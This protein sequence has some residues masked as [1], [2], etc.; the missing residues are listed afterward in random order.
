MSEELRQQQRNFY[1]R[2]SPIEGHDIASEEGGFVA[3]SDEAMEHEL[4]D[5]LKLWLTLQQSSA[6]EIIANCAWWMTQYMDPEKRL[7]A[8]DGVES[9]DKLTSYAVAVIGLLR[10][11]GVIQFLEE[12][13]LPEIRL[14]SEHDFDPSQLEFLKYLD[15]DA[16]LEEGDDEQ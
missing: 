14:S 13:E 12:P 10:D 15:F 7:G 16:L 9:L 1:L 6:G 2:L 8:T 3:P 5:I 4:R 11:A